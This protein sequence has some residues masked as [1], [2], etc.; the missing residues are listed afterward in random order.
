MQHHF[1]VE[2][3]TRYGM[4]EAIILNNLEFWT[5]RNEAN[6]QH[7]HDG[8]YW[9]YNSTKALAKLFPYVSQRQIQLALKHL[10]ELGIIQTGNYNKQP[11]DRTLWYAF[12]DLGLSIMQKCQME[13]ADLSNGNAP[14]VQPIPDIKP[15]AKPDRKPD[16]KRADALREIIYA[17]TEDQ[18]L[19]ATIWDF[20]EM[21]RQMKAPMTEKGLK[22]LLSKLE[23][24]SSDA[25]TQM[26]I[27]NQSI[28]SGWKSVYPLKD[29]KPQS[30]GNHKTAIGPNG[31]EYR[32][33]EE[34]DEEWNRIW[35]G[36]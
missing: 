25:S 36:R 21:R 5:A 19:Q 20:I 14:Q 26:A 30:A 24:L 18:E 35:G 27:V 8:Y 4:L 33:D 22:L 28:E 3:A 7:H 31:V 11:Y 34:E 10:R 2:L 16:K 13:D 12:T 6:G 29:N 32:I 17:F 9:T 15:D 1:D 23:K